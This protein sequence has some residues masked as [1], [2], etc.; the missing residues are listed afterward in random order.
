M[1][2]IHIDEHVSFL[3]AKISSLVWFISIRIQWPTHTPDTPE[4]LFQWTD[5]GPV[6]PYLWTI[7]IRLF[8]SSNFGASV[9]SFDSQLVCLS[10]SLSKFVYIKKRFHITYYSGLIIWRLSKDNI[11]TKSIYSRKFHC[12]HTLHITYLLS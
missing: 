3:I 4:K 12:Q 11:K 9:Y 1:G 7:F 6:S 8:S 2:S 5:F 10:V